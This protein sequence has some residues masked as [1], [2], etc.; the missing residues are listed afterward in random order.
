MAFG[1]CH[2]FFNVMGTDKQ[3]SKQQALAVKCFWQPQ[4]AAV[5]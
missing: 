1:Y 2:V 5:I 3:L 4:Q